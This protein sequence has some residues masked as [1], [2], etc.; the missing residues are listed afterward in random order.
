MNTVL[1]KP[2][3]FHTASPGNWAV[4]DDGTDVKNKLENGNTHVQRGQDSQEPEKKCSKLVQNRELH[5]ICAS[6]RDTAIMKALAP[7]L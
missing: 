7:H 5:G 3:A 1:L 6:Q 2:S 4:P